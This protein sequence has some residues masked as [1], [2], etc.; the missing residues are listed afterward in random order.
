MYSEVANRNIAG[1]RQFA[2]RVFPLPRVVSFLTL[3]YSYWLPHNT[4]RHIYLRNW[5][6]PLLENSVNIIA[7]LLSTLGVRTHV[8]TDS[9][10]VKYRLRS[11][12]TPQN[13]FDRIKNCIKRV[14]LSSGFAVMVFV[15]AGSV[16]TA[17]YLRLNKGTCRP[18]Y[19]PCPFNIYTST[20][21]ALKVNAESHSKSNKAQQKFSIIHGI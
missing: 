16:F 8:G 7:W 4:L 21:C 14:K 5:S 10:T 18:S 20:L 6:L 13:L 17:R 2:T 12:R 3:L 1:S 11:L 19:L 9:K 15:F